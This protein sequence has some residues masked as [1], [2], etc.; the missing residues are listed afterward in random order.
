MGGLPQLRWLTF[1]SACH[2]AFPADNTM[3][4]KKNSDAQ[5]PSTDLLM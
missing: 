3:L 4:A 1:V 2:A 5:P